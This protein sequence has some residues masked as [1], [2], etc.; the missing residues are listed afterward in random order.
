[1]VVVISFKELNDIFNYFLRLIYLFVNFGDD[2][3]LII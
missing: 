2:F 1:M 3:E